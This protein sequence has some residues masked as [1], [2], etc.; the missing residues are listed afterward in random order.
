[1]AMDFFTVPT[2]SFKILY[3]YFIIDHTRRKIVHFNVTEYPTAE[4]VIQQLRNAFP[5]E[6]APRYLIFDRDWI[7]SARVKQFIT[8]MAQDQKLQ[9][10][11][12]KWRGRTLCPFSS[13]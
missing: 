12:A 3:V 6:S 1:M 4:R 5:F 11:L 8:N 9:M 2:V 13:R 10:P 7:F